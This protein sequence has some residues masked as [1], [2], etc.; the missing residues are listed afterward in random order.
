MDST[1]LIEKAKS[2]FSELSSKDLDWKSFYTGYLDGYA[3]KDIEQTRKVT[4]NNQEFSLIKLDPTSSNGLKFIE[5]VIIGSYSP[6]DNKM[7]VL[8]DSTTYE[9]YKELM[10]YDKRCNCTRFIIKI[11]DA[12]WKIPKTP[13]YI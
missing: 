8:H 7:I 9:G 1:K 6:R 2:R 10:H 3:E 11:K 5:L 12:Q 13:I 4:V